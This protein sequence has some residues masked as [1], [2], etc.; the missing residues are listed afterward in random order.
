MFK[1]FVAILAAVMLAVLALV[2]MTAASA[3]SSTMYVS[4]SNGL[5]VNLRTGPDKSTRSMVKLGVGFPVNVVDYDMGW[6]EVTAKVNGKTLHGYINSDYLAG[7]D[8]ATRSQKFKSVN[9]FTVTVRPSSANGKVNLWPSASKKG[10]ELRTLTKG[11]ALTV[12]AASNAWYKV[13]DSQGNTGY[14]AKAYVKK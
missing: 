8:P 9:E 10:S 12:V 3:G 4:A 6:Y 1:K 2:P 14:V 11:E 5:S 13:L 7:S